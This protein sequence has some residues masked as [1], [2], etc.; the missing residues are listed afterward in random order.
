LVVV[1]NDLR[2]MGLIRMAREGAH[3]G[4]AEP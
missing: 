3:M 1:F 2:G 4:F